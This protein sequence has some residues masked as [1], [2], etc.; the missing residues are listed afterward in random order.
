MDKNHDEIVIKNY[1]HDIHYTDISFERFTDD[2]NW[3]LTTQSKDVIDKFILLNTPSNKLCR[4]G[5][6]CLDSNKGEIICTEFTMDELLV[7]YN[8]NWEIR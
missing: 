4:I 5:R 3:I 6:S 8:E 1:G 2:K 7:Y